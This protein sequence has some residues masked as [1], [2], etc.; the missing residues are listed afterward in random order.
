MRAVLERP[1]YM[2]ALSSRYSQHVCVCGIVD[3]EFLTRFLNELFDPTHSCCE[4]SADDSGSDTT[5]AACCCCCCYCGC[6][7]E[8]TANDATDDIKILNRNDDKY[9]HH[10]YH[11]H[12]HPKLPIIV[13]LLS[14]VEPSEAVKHMLRLPAFRD[15]IFYFVGSGKNPSSLSRIRLEHSA[16]VYVMSDVATTSLREEE[17]S[18]FLTSLSVINYLKRHVNMIT[19]N[20]ASNMYRH[21]HKHKHSNNGS[22]SHRQQLHHVN[23]PAPAAA[24]GSD[25]NSIDVHSSRAMLASRVD[26]TSEQQQQ[27]QPYRQSDC[28]SER[29]WPWHTQSSQQRQRPSQQQ[30][31][32]QWPRTVAR[33][34]WTARC[35]QVLV[36]AGFDTVLS[37]QVSYIHT[38]VYEYTY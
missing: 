21:K 10:F 28:E 2:G 5:S 24:D 26:L 33:L 34:P 11:R 29:P 20:R 31:H 23:A 13:T 37:T 22:H 7:N 16:A 17:D 35:R 1:Q 4:D 9:N 6:N 27:Q 38:W 18:I 12:R 15:K 32:R 8:G 19:C 36:Q 25:D 14:P 30:Q 3:A